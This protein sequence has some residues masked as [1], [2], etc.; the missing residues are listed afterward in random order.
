MHHHPLHQN[1]TVECLCCH[2][3]AEM[4][5][6]SQSDHVICKGCIRH[7][8]HATHSLQLRD[9]D[10]INLW[11]SELEIEKEARAAE[12]RHAKAAAD[13]REAELLRVRQE[14]SDLRG[15]LKAEIDQRPVATVERWFQGEAITAAHVERDNSY[16]SRDRALQIIW[17][18]D[19]LHHDDER[20]N[21]LCR[22]GKRTHQCR[23]WK[24]LEPT[25]AFLYKSENQQVD[26]LKRNL[27]HGLPDDHPEV[28]KRG[29][30]WRFRN[31]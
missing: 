1:V 11:W 18:L 29:S 8:G 22:C 31:Y 17:N 4:C 30:G 3:Q 24:V 14:L 9:F 25:R 15:A 19:K 13:L 10:H 21:N 27:P 6:G 2:V 5:F 16:R 12:R 23:E 28:L 20:K 26:R 7:Q